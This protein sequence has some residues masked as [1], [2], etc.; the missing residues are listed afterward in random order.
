ML[1][2]ALPAK[3]LILDGQNPLTLL[4]RPLSVG[5]HGL[6]DEECMQQ[7]ADIGMVLRA[8]LE[9]VADVLKDQ[10]ALRDA[11]ARLL[12]GRAT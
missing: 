10:N 1:R 2:D 12:S 11:A 8:V 7:A 4:Y 3:L 6:S 9:N 5:L